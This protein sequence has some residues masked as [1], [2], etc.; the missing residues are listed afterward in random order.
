MG[1]LQMPSLGAGM[2]SGVVVAFRVKPGDAV[3][4]GDIVAEVETEKGVIE[5]EVF[6][7]G[8]FDRWLVEPGTKLAVGEPIAR[9]RAEGEPAA[10]PEPPAQPPA[11]APEPPAEAPA[12]P[13]APAPEPLAAPAAHEH[14]RGTPGARRL[15]REAGIDL[16]DVPG[17]GAY[18]VV[19]RG[20]VLRQLHHLEP[21]PRPSP[22]DHLAAAPT[23][24]RVSPLARRRAGELGVDVASL[25]PGPD[26]AVHLAQV[27]AAAAA[28]TQDT[29]A[30]MRRAIAVAMS[31]AKRE[32]PHY[33]LAHS[34]DLG[35]ATAWLEQE[36]ARRP[37]HE[38][39]LLG[40]LLLRA[41]ARAVRA[42]PELNAHWL[43]DS[44]P[45]IAQ[46]RLGVA[47]SLRQ[48]GLIA[49]AIADAD[50]LPLDALMQAFKELVQRTR[51]GALR[52]SELAGGT[53]TVTSLG[54]RGVETVYP[55]INPPQ[56]A[57][58]GFGKVAERPWV[59]DGAVVPRPVITAT[60]AADHRVSDGHRGGLY[61][62][63]LERL[64][65]HPELLTQEDA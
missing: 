61:L 46:V 63:E 11:E 42:V 10:A 62:A 27:E 6:E 48:G 23:R 9:L 51:R 12:A 56:V 60:L 41:A 33:Y 40:V 65:V 7:D 32:I 52:G 36:N 45:P 28:R 57:M 15:A 43:G 5:I 22:H 14:H 30:A 53:L 64:L 29:G 24:K 8:V 1:E 13:A 3:R 34:M 38:R 21:A 2:E 19:T 50:R 4:R 54:E 59:V 37:L 20:D 47:I 35:P 16:D 39:L 49:P 31:R 17:T 25:A 26:G 58:V 44:A 18:G 55:I